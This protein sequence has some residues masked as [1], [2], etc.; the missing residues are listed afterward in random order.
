MV[1][2]GFL[3]ATAFYVVVSAHNYTAE[4][5]TYMTAIADLM[6]QGVPRDAIDAGW[7]WNGEH[8]F[9]RF[10]S[11]THYYKGWYRTRDYVVT[12]RQR[13]PKYEL[14][15]RYSVPRWRIW[16]KAGLTVNVYGR[17]NEG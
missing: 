12:V 10:K 5:R 17:P 14:L 16:G 9:G 11:E 1:S 8:G 6:A 13:E 2:G 4:K 3:A 15:R 7:V